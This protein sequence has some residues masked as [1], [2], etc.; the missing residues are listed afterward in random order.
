MLRI[1]ANPRP[2][3]NHQYRLRASTRIYAH[4]RACA[5]SGKSPRC[6]DNAVKRIDIPGD[7]ISKD[8]GLACRWPPVTALHLDQPFFVRCHLKPITSPPMSEQHLIALPPAYPTDAIHT[9]FRGAQGPHPATD[10]SAALLMLQLQHA[11]IAAVANA[12][13]LLAA[14]FLANALNDERNSCVLQHRLD[15]TM[16]SCL[17][18]DVLHSCLISFCVPCRRP[19]HNPRSRRPLAYRHLQV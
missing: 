1:H 19:I 10:V 15:T 14:R 11:D 17:R 7:R 9:H 5:P 13:R 2:S 18:F 6:D 4:L 8:T 16:V 3:M 12:N